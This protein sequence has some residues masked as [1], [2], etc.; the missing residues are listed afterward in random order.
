M[1]LLKISKTLNWDSSNQHRQKVRKFGVSQ[2]LRQY[3]RVKNDKESEL[4]WGDEIECGIWKL[5]HTNKRVSISCRGPEVFR[6]FMLSFNLV[7]LI[8]NYIF[9][10]KICLILRKMNLVVL[11]VRVGILSMELG[12]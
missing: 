2:F 12:W 3:S 8:I 7:F 6:I 9:R 5:D 11:K 10:F 4:K 1:G